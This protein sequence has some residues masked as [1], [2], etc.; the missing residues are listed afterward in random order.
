LS[1]KTSWQWFVY[2]S[3]V[4]HAQVAMAR[5]AYTRR[6]RDDVRERDEISSVKENAVSV[7]RTRT[8]SRIGRARRKDA[9][10]RN[11]VSERSMK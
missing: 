7:D 6:W 9:F 5:E 3:E 4:A 10:H 11:V 2:G 8:G 1:M